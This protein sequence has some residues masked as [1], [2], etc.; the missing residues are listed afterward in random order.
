MLIISHKS[1]QQFKEF[2]HHHGFEFILTIDN[3]KLDPRIADHPD[4]S[5]FVLNKETIVVDESVYDYYKQV[6]INKNIIKGQS[7]SIKYPNDAIYNIYKASNFYIH[8]DIS[9]INILNYLDNNN[10]IHYYVKQ[11]YTRCSIIP[12]GDKILTS[13]Y[14][15][16]KA[17]RNQIEVVL[18]ESETITL[19][20]FD[21]GFIGGT[22]GLVGNHLIFDGNIKTSVN[23]QKI[24]DEADKSSIKLLYPDTDL[25]DLGSIID[26]G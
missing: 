3:P 6:L 7:V 21:T 9:E 22:C 11:G 19:D 5:I 8:N 24:K 20:G 10:Y 12:M 17:L 25:I 2:L 23:Y 1:S 14:G 18:L 15:M 16:Y 26:I 4:L 13:D